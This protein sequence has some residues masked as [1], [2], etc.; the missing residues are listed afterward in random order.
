MAISPEVPRPESQVTEIPTVPEL[1]PE[2]EHATG[3]KVV[4]KNFTAQVKSD[5]GVPL[6]STPPTQVVAV[7]P[8]ANSATLISWAKGPITSSISWLGLFWIRILKKATHFGWQV[9]QK[10]EK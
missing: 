8:P 2:V 6:I 5:K 10:E 9:T 3:V 4:Q 7:T 1:P